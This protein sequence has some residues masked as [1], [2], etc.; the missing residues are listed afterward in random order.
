M[1]SILRT[2]KQNVGLKEITVSYNEKFLRRY[3]HNKKSVSRK[4]IAKSCWSQD[5]LK[6]EKN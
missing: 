4:A 2:S 5:S 1:K 6:R 3:S